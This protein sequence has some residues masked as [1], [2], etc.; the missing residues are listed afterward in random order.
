MSSIYITQSADRLVEYSV[1]QGCIT[2]LRRR[3]VCL[4]I[5]DLE[6]H[7]QVISGEQCRCPKGGLHVGDQECCGQTF[8]RGIADD[9]CQAV[10]L[11]RDHVVAI[12]AEGP[13]LTAAR[14]IVEGIANCRVRLH[15]AALHV[16]GRYP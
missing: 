14:A 6:Q 8:S 9:K 12:A 10:V 2:V 13:N 7:A 5:Y 3:D 4:L 1:E 15:K 11:K 16:A